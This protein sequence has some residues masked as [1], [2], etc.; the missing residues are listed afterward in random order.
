M[1][2]P[3]RMARYSR[4]V[5]AITAEYDALLEREPGRDHEPDRGDRRATT[6]IHP[7]IPP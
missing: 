6:H 1:P 2:K 4:P 5:A 3:V 7:M